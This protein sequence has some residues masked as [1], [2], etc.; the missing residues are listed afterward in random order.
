MTKQPIHDGIIPPSEV[1]RL[2]DAYGVPQ[3]IVITFD[4]AAPE[5]R[6]VCVATY[7]VTDVD[8]GQAAMAGRQ[9]AEVIR[10]QPPSLADALEAAR[11]IRPHDVLDN[12]E[13]PDW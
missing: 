7:G 12:E 6:R 5:Q 13:Y 8:A 1:E 4:P 2:V 10:R 11:A 3:G 9:L